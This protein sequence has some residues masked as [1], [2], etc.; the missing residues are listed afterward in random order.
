MGWSDARAGYIL[1]FRFLSAPCTFR[2]PTP[3]SHRRVQRQR[4]PLSP[5][6]WRGPGEVHVHHPLAE[7][8]GAPQKKE[9]I[10]TVQS[11]VSTAPGHLETTADRHRPGRLQALPCCQERFRGEV[12]APRAVEAKLFQDEVGLP[13][14]Q[15]ATGKPSL[16]VLA[17][18]SQAA[19]RWGANGAG[20]PSKEYP[21]RQRFHVNLVLFKAGGVYRGCMWGMP[22]PPEGD[23]YLE[24]TD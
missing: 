9:Q 20:G 6:A 16:P 18:V 1:A 13:G 5:H 15:P 4:L 7:R 14:H 23:L 2:F 24:S 19:A 10:A 17:V 3:R 8:R 22:N 21:T 11:R 12:A